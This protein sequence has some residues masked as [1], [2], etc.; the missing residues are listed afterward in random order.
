[1]IWL[2]ELWSFLV[3]RDDQRVRNPVADGLDEREIEHSNLPAIG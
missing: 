2:N 1:M 3:D